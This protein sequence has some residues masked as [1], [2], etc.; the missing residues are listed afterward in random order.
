MDFANIL[1]DTMVAAQNEIRLKVLEEEY[2]KVKEINAG[3][4]EALKGMLLWVRRVEA[5]NPG[6]EIANA[7]NA[8]AKAEGK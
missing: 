1:K 7:Y 4:L 3:L 2:L 6:I 5:V 8:I